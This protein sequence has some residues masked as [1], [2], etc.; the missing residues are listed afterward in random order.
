MYVRACMCVCVCVHASVRACV[1]VRNAKGNEQKLHSVKKTSPEV[2]TLQSTMTV[3]TIH[4]NG[5]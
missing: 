5:G 4:P 1:Y 2:P 3:F